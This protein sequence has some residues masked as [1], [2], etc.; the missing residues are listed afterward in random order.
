MSQTWVE[1]FF[2]RHYA[3]LFTTYCVGTARGDRLVI[4]NDPGAWAIPMEFEAAL[5]L[6]Y[7]LG[8]ASLDVHLCNPVLRYTAKPSSACLA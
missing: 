4:A 5:H 1:L 8:D 3:F 7:I 2:E 6:Y